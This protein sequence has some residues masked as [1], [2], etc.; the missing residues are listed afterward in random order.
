MSR[1]KVYYLSEFQTLEHCWKRLD[2]L[3]PIDTLRKDNNAYGESIEHVTLKNQVKRELERLG[4]YVQ[5]EYV[6][7]NYRLDVYAT[8]GSEIVIVECGN[9]AEEK[10]ADLRRR[11]KNVIHIPFNTLLPF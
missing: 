8:K 4:F 11:F 3:T 6:F 7:E 5:T 9:C 10:L 2:R 1:K